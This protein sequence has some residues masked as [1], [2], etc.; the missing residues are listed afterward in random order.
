MN[1]YQLFYKVFCIFITAG[2]S[3]ISSGQISVANSSAGNKGSVLI[4]GLQFT[5]IGKVLKPGN[6]TINENEIKIVAAGADI[7]GKH[8]D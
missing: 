2:I 7:W 4:S 1:I 5:D 3:L 8:Q 6:D